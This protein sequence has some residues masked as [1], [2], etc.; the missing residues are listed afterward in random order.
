MN[1]HLFF[2]I[3]LW[4]FVTLLVV[5][6][7]FTGVA[8]G[9]GEKISALVEG[10]LIWTLRTLIGIVFMGIVF[11]YLSFPTIFNKFQIPL[12]IEVRILGSFFEIIGV[13]LYTWTHFHLGKNFTD[14]VI[15]RK[16]AHLV[17]SGPYQYM[18]H[19]M[20]VS[21]FFIF[22]G[23]FLMSEIWLV[24]FLGG[25]LLFLI[26]L[27]RTPE[28]ERRLVQEFGSAYLSYKERVGM[29][30]PKPKA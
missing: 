9:Q 29:F 2:I 12:S 19:P 7:Y 14:T 11:L 24:A 6:A 26:L 17:Q 13:I 22:G 18:R 15:V 27:F 8:Y 20:Y 3:A 28:E 25:L 5:R 23:G 16:G 10:K 4:S 30:F 1:N 21:A